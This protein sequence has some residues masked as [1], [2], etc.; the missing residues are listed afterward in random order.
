[1]QAA[2]GFWAAKAPARKRNLLA[3]DPEPVSAS[4]R[5]IYHRGTGQT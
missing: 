4:Y 5:A 3:N 1:M 2:I